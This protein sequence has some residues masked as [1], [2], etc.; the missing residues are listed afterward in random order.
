MLHLPHVLHVSGDFPDPL[1]DAKTPVI[2]TLLALTADQFDHSVISIN[3]ANPSMVEALLAPLRPGTLRIASEPFPQGDA[4]RYF[5]PSHGVLHASS[6]KQLGE[7][8]AARVAT[9]PRRPDLLVGH[10]LTIEG[11]A[12]ARAAELL[13]LPYALSI[14]G[15]TDTKILAARPDLGGVFRTVLQNAAFVFP[16]TPWAWQKISARLGAPQSPHALLPCP[17]D[18]DEPLP[19][20]RGGNGFLSVFHLKNF[21][22]KNLSGMVR[23]LEELDDESATLTVVGGG[24]AK[25]R[26]ACTRLIRRH[27]QIILAGPLGRADVRT[28]LNQA[29]AFVMPSLRESFGL[30]FI[31]ALFAGTPV[32]YPAGSAIDGYFDGFPFAIAVDARNPKSIA[33]A[34]RTARDN[35]GELKDALAQWQG[36]THARQFQRT[37]I[38][39]RFAHGLTVA[40]GQA[41]IG[42]SVTG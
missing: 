4:L 29:T 34:L 14:Q 21:R 41:P 32:I 23:A 38:A 33:K 24:D 20:V 25:D 9:M 19:P 10:K 36:S 35:E 1:Q 13:E 8:I 30:V 40:L 6:L 5:A 22:R 11:L 12:V 7:W 3:R 27:R 28:R 16:F 26:A 37:Q 2:S 39:R 17:T 15:D 31:E 18:L 42:A